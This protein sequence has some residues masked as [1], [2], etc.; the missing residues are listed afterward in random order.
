MSESTSQAGRMHTGREY[1]HNPNSRL[2]NI[3]NEKRTKLFYNRPFIH[4]RLPKF[5]LMWGFGMCFWSSYYIRVKYQWMQHSATVTSKCL[6]KTVPFVQAMEDIRFNAISERNFMILKAI[7][8]SENPAYFE[9][10][11]KRFNQEDFFQSYSKGS[12]NR[13][14]DDGRFTTSR[15]WDMNTYR[16]PEDENYLVGFQEQSNYS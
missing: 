12:T 6:K 10:L 9:A 1:V 16:K 13:D 11:R 3:M 15:W 14:G 5:I 8:D 7:C 4:G 2:R